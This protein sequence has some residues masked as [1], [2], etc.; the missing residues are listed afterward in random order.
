M[1]CYLCG[2]VVPDE[3][4]P[5]VDWDHPY[6]AACIEKVSNRRAREILALE[7][8]KSAAGKEQIVGAQAPVYPKCVRCGGDVKV[9]CRVVIH[10]PPRY[11]HGVDFCSA[12]ADETVRFVSRKK[13]E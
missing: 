4:I 2:K 3:K 12:C 6:C 10:A 7:N 5:I 11:I 9:C 8:G 1:K 13:K